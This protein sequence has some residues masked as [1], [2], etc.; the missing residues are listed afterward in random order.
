MRRLL[1]L[2]LSAALVAAC[3]ASSPSTASPSP[4]GS[5]T[6][7]GGIELAVA[8]GVAHLTGSASDAASA[9][10]AI[11]AFGLDLYAR[12]LDGNG[13]LVISP[14]SVALAL[15]MARAG[16]G[17]TTATEMDAVLHGLASDAHAAWV[18]SLDGALNARTGTFKDQDGK[19]QTVTLRIANASFAQQGLTLEPA[20]LDA[21]AAQFGAGVRLVDFKQASEPARIAINAWVADQTEQRIKELLAQGTLNALTR[22]VLVNA[23][24]LK[25][26]WLTPFEPSATQPAAFHRLDGSTVDV[27][28]MHSGGYLEYASGSGWQAVELPYV[29]RQLAMLVIVPD[30]LAA[31]E[32]GFDAAALDAITGGLASREVA[33]SMPRFGAE[34][35]TGLAELLAAIGMPSAFDPS[36]AD[37]SGITADEPL[38]ISAVIHQ[39]NIDVD[40][41]GTEAAA[42]TAVAMAAAGAPSESVT[43]KVDRPF[44]FAV[45]DLETGAVLFLGRITDASDGAPA[46]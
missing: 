31:F 22:L 26:A 40:E 44:V 7:A 2:L 46:S 6:G 3:A 10:A 43:L 9:G 24:Y 35:S 8:D 12:V 42:A 45:R 29:G 30:D 36:S 17:G 14:A 4:T 11:N 39:A 18:A 5:P 13:N 21:L 23:I 32:A 19:P 15:A 25:A 34:T 20:Y 16:A 41:A 27:P 28:F 38:F 37:F 33:L 1:A